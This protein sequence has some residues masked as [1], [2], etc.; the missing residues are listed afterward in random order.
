M[1]HFIKPEYLVS[2]YLILYKTDIVTLKDLGDYAGKLNRELIDRK[3]E[4]VFLFSDK[5]IEEMLNHYKD[6]FISGTYT[7]YDAVKRIVPNEVLSEQFISY[8]SNDVAKVACDLQEKEMIMTTEEKIEV[9]KAFTEGKQIQ[10]LSHETNQWEDV[11]QYPLWD[12]PHYEYRVK[13]EPTYRPYKDVNEML[14]DL[15]KRLDENYGG[16]QHPVFSGMWLKRNDCEVEEMI[17]GTNQSNSYVLI[18]TKWISLETIF[19]QYNYLD[20][21]RFGIK[22]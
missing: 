19:H 1:T 10:F 22:E 9:M 5:Y 20:G 12:W 16:I 7:I 18:G 11:R 21:T 14:D 13:P 6:C 15:T 4:A 2:L 8:L 3:I 17:A